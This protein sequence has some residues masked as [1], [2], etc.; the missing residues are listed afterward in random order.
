MR[1]LLIGCGLALTIALVTSVRV[2]QD[3]RDHGYWEANVVACEP[4]KVKV[5][6]K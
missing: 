3:G 1:T 6:G 5:I 4:R 2:W